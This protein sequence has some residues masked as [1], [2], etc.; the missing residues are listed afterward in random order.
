MRPLKA[1]TDCTVHVPAFAA[2]YRENRA[3]GIFHVVMDDGNLCD[4]RGEPST[5]EEER[6]AAVFDLMTHSQR[7]K[8]AVLAE[9]IPWSVDV[10]DNPS[11]D[12]LAARV[13]VADA[14]AGLG[15]T[16]WK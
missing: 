5:E 12:E 8:V 7:A 13:A 3:W 6:L 16:S 14:L 10:S 9:C 11:R 4:Y 2:Y 1:V 15:G